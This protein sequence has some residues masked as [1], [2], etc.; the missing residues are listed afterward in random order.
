MTLLKDYFDLKNLKSI[1]QVFS[2]TAKMHSLEF[3]SKQF[4]SGYKKKTI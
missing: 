1:T 3:N 2:N 4:E